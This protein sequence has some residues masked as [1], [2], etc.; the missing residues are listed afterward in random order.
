MF[1]KLTAISDCFCDGIDATQPLLLCHKPRPLPAMIIT[2]PASTLAASLHVHIRT[3]AHSRARARTSARARLAR[4]RA[5]QDP[6]GSAPIASLQLTD[7]GIFCTCTG[8]IVID[9]L[10]T[11]DELACRTVIESLLLAA[12]QSDARDQF[13]RCVCTLSLPLHLAPCPTLPGRGVKGGGA[14]PSVVA[15]LHA[16]PVPVRTRGL[17]R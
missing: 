9:L 3:F 10:I 4:T 8:M 2:R 11:G 6:G 13:I 16:P 7:P 14:L 5:R 1:A 12:I 17:G 15:S